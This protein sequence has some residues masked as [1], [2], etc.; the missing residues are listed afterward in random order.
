[1]DNKKVELGKEAIENLNTAKDLVNKAYWMLIES[2]LSA[3]DAKTICRCYTG[4]LFGV[5]DKQ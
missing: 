1:M 4:R 2:G 5:E 3:R